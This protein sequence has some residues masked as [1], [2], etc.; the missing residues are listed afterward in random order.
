M[1]VQSWWATAATA[2]WTAG[3]PRDCN[4][5]WWHQWVIAG[6]TLGDGDCGGTIAMGHNGGSAMDD[7]M[8]VHS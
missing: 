6:V 3:W 4:E 7:G 2:Q 8:A 5:Q 1:A